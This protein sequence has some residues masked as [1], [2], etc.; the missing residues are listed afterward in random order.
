MLIGVSYIEIWTGNGFISNLV[1]IG[2]IGAFYFYINFY[3]NIR[4]YNKSIYSIYFFTLIIL[5]LQ[6][7]VLLMYPF[8]LALPFMVIKSSQ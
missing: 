4:K 3:R 1:H 6:G 5:S 2:I 8:Y 7:E